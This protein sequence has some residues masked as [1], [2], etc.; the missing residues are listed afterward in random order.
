MVKELDHHQLYMKQAVRMI[1]LVKGHHQLVYLEL[2]LLHGPEKQAVVSERQIKCKVLELHTIHVF[3]F[4]L[5]HTVMIL[6][7]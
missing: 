5:F 1:Q 7:V 4:D 6:H 2:M 3:L